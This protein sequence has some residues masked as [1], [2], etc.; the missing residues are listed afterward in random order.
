MSE[1]YEDSITFDE[2][3]RDKEFDARVLGR[4]RLNKKLDD[5][6][7]QKYLSS[8]EDCADRSEVVNVGDIM[9]NDNPIHVGRNLPTVERKDPASFEEFELEEQTQRFFEH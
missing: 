8:L 1:K 4:K 2:C 3:L 5:A 6:E 9:A 7:L